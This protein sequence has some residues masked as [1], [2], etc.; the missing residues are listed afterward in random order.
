M[1]TTTDP[2]QESTSN[3]DNLASV[4]KTPPSA[5]NVSRGDEFDG[6]EAASSWKGLDP[7][8]GG[9]DGKRGPNTAPTV[10]T[11]TNVKK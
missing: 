7:N 3:D 2:K 1:S 8:A 6:E 4:A 5:E 10:G 11:G 9:W